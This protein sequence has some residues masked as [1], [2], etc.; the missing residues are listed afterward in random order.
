MHRARFAALS[1]AYRH[2]DKTDAYV[3]GA[4]AGTKYQ[5]MDARTVVVDSGRHIVMEGVEAYGK[6]GCQ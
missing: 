4:K 3:I 1:A 2:L 6:Q 5:R